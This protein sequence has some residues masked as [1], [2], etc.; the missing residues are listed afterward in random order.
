[1]TATVPDLVAAYVAERIDDGLADS[2]AARFTTRLTAWHRHA[3]APSRWTA[4]TVSAWAYDPALAP[5]TR[6]SYAKHLRSYMAWLVRRGDLADDLTDDVARVRVPKPNP[7]DLTVAQVR[8]LVAVLPDDRA[9]LIVLVMAQAGLRAG[10]LARARV[11]DVDVDRR[12]LAVRGKGG[13]GEVTHWVPL[14]AEAW[15]YVERRLARPE[16]GPWLVCSERFRQGP[17]PMTANHLSRLVARWLRAAGIT[18]AGIS[19]HSLRHSCA[20]HMLDAGADI[21]QVQHA[22][23]HSSVT[24]TE[25]YLRRQP[26]G[27]RDAMEGRTYT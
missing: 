13:Q 11:D 9:R 7:R 10:D 14:P 12:T 21:R 19:S 26:P 18:G 16:L 15:G 25:Q 27:L 24:I 4:D 17:E 3:G 8:D 20:Q 23:G 6:R 5:A 2:T 22:L 1:M